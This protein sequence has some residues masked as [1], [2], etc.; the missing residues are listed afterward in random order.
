MSRCGPSEN[1]TRASA[2]RAARTEAIGPSQK[3]IPVGPSGIEPDLHAPHACVLPVY[4][5]P[6]TRS[7]V[8]PLGIEPDFTRFAARDVPRTSRSGLCRGAENRTRSLR[9]RSV[10]TTGILRPDRFLNTKSYECLW[11]AQGSVTTLACWLGRD[12]T[13]FACAQSGFRSRRTLTRAAALG[14]LRYLVGSTGIEPVTLR[15]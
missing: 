14:I 5:G 6:F 3:S 2:M 4:Y 8:G 7:L 15:V 11:A 1:R 13:S 9:T 12:P 10:C